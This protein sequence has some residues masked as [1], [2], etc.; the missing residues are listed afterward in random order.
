MNDIIQ[1]LWIG[2]KLSEIERLCISS[3]LKNGHTFHLYTYE[4][5]ENVPEG[6]VLIDANSIISKDL[7]FL[8]SH[9]TWAAFSDW[10][11]YKLLYQNGGWWSDLDVVCV[12][13][14]NFRA[15]YV[16]ASEKVNSHGEENIITTC[17]IKSPSGADY[18]KELLAYIESSD[19]KDVEWGTLGPN[20]F[21]YV[22]QQYASK[23]YIKS[24]NLFCPISW[25]ETDLL[26]SAQPDY[27]I[28]KSFTVHLWN[29]IWRR[30]GID[31]NAQYD[32]LC[33][34]EKLKSRYL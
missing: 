21:N 24:P 25:Y 9:S 23:K 16:F 14:L 4:E 26:F 2:S 13:K 19:F 7:M 31:K 11:R 5:I 29:E 10:F 20:L 12:K 15:Q 34:L 30:K 32:S 17:L 28:E 1:G 6:A 8:D 27:D 3:F 18:L 33:V 22:V